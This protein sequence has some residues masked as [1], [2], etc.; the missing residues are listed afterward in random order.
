MRHDQ[1]NRA[2]ALYSLH[3]GCVARLE[4]SSL[5]DD[6]GLR[7]DLQLIMDQYNKLIDVTIVH[8]TCPS[9]VKQA[10]TQLKTAHDACE[11]KTNKYMKLAQQQSA[12]FVPFAVESFGGLS[13][14]ATDLINEISVFASEHL[15]AWS[16][17]EII[18]DLTSA[19]AC[20]IQR[21]NAIAALSG[22]Q[23]CALSA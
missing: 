4:P 17:E 5:S 18:E 22:Y 8:P 6:N 11:N 3:A 16:K 14:S 2:L 12:D 19:I 9:H 20:A 21:G 13:D 10:Q 15:S 7:P 23:A 1:V